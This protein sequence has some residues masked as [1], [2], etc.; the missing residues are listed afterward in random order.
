[1]STR[2][3]GDGE[4]PRRAQAVHVAFTVARDLEGDE[5]PHG[6]AG[7]GKEIIMQR[8]FAMVLAVALIAG[9]AV[10]AMT[11][12]G[13]RVGMAQGLAEAGKLPAAAAPNAYYGPMWHPPFFFGG[14]LFGLLFFLLVLSAL[15]RGA[16]GRH[17]YAA[18]G[19]CGSG[20]PPR[21]EEW[22]RRAHE[23]MADGAPRA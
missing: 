13:Y 11:S 14:P 3:A 7:R 4:R 15:R 8:R 17:A 20:V 10:M 22:H 18:G 21:F 12:Y 2:S 6:N 1:M 9:L 23:S 5:G 16:W 19:G